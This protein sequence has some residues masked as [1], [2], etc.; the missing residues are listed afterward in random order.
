MVSRN[1]PIQPFKKSALAG[2]QIREYAVR[3]SL[4][5]DEED[6]AAFSERVGK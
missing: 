3:T 5:E 1:A 4:Q 6:F 2:R